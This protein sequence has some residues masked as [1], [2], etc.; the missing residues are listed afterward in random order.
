MCWDSG[1]PDRPGW[2]LAGRRPGAL[3][4]TDVRPAAGRRGG[5]VLLAAAAQAVPRRQGE[6]RGCAYLP[7]ARRLRSRGALQVRPAECESAQV[8]HEE[9]DVQ[10][11]QWT[12][13]LVVRRRDG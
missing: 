1:Q 6:Q 2:I 11:V 4:G 13:S 5:P 12:I 8:V 3:F 10:D 9:C 7:G